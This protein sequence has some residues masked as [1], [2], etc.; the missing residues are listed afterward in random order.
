MEKLVWPAAFVVFAV[1]GMVLF[2]SDIS[3]MIARIAAING[4]GITLVQ[5][6]DMS[7]LI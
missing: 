7:T 2:K 3:A 6:I 5:Q 1:I 4:N